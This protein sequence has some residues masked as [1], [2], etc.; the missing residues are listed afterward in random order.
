[1]AAAKRIDRATGQTVR[2]KL[3]RTLEVGNAR[4]IREYQEQAQ[5]ARCGKLIELF[6]NR[7]LVALGLNISP[8][9]LFKS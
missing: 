9:F 2:E 8:K 6:L 1:V 5:I 7:T 3:G 4:G